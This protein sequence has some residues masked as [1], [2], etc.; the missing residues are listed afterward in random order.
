MT[1]VLCGLGLGLGLMIAVVGTPASAEAHDAYDDSQSH[2]LRLV[3]YLL[4]PV[5][6]A[7]EWLIMRPIH[8]AVSQ[9]QLERVFCHTP[10]EDPFSYDPYRGE[11][12]E[13]Y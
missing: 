11:E 1:K 8:F 10:H 7:T 6:F 2:P 3:A 9:P 12:P 5:G 4:N 13:G